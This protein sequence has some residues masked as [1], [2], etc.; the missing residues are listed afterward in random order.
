[1]QT[2]DSV[3]K[4]KYTKKQEDLLFFLL[5]CAFLFDNQR[6]FNICVI[7]KLL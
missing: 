7:M 1:M 5:F 3:F 4:V 6:F 2:D